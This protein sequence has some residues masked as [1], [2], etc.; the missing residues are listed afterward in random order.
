MTYVILVIIAL[1]VYVDA[2]LRKSEY[3][4][5][6]TIACLSLCLIMLP[7][8]LANRPLKFDE[9]RIGGKTWNSLK[10]FAAFCSLIWLSNVIDTLFFT[11]N[12]NI[13]KFLVIGVEFVVLLIFL[14]IS[15]IL[16]FFFKNNS[17]VEESDEE[18]EDK[19]VFERNKLKI[20]IGSFI[21][22]IASGYFCAFIY[23]LRTYM[24]F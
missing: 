21:T 11:S 24:N 18:S 15:L 19:E 20:I 23:G 17:I 13:D 7:I 10:Y 9:S 6:W 2:I 8:Y 16:G 5:L 4:I 14:V 12:P 22:V 1:W 3:P